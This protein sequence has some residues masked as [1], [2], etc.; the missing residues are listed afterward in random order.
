MTEWGIEVME[1]FVKAF[2]GLPVFLYCVYH[3]VMQ[4]TKQNRQDSIF[5]RKSF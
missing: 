3:Q 2:S 5:K 1:D 4:V